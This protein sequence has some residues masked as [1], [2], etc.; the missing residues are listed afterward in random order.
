MTLGRYKAQRERTALI[1]P[2]VLL[3]HSGDG[4]P[5][6]PA[7]LHDVQLIPHVIRLP[8]PVVILTSDVELFIDAVSGS[9]KNSGLFLDAPFATIVK[10]LDLIR[11]FDTADFKITV[12]VAAGF[13]SVPD[14]RRPEVIGG[15]TVWEGDTTFLDSI[16][17]SGFDA[18]PT[19]DN[20][21][22]NVDFLD[23]MVKLPR[24]SSLEIGHFIVVTEAFDGQNPGMAN[25]SHEV[26]AWDADRQIAT[27]RLW[28]ERDSRKV[29]QGRITATGYVVRSIVNFE[30]PDVTNLQR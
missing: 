4:T 25:G 16:V 15:A 22:E 13:H 17:L 6:F 27:T 1:V 14:R 2:G 23:F 19:K 12:N 18:T 21:F 8:D 29:P 5:D 3:P 9:D 28:L 20:E 24:N 7:A 26:I 10:A 11:A 30:K